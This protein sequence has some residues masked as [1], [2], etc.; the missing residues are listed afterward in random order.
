MTFA[1]TLYARWRVLVHELAKFGIVG[2]INTVVDFGIFN[3]LRV[4]FDVPPL[5]ATAAAL[6]VAATSSY[7]MNRH[8]TFRHRARSG[9]RREYSLFFVLNGVGLLIQLSCLSVS[10]YALGFDS[11]FADN[12]AKAVGLVIG[13]VFRFTSYKRWVFLSH[14]R[15]GTVPLEVAVG[16]GQVSY[17]ADVGRGQHSDNGHARSGSTELPATERT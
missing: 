4:A 6:T 9:L 11:L 17:A 5:P 1:K 2:A 10:H 14:E 13:T 7:L 12:V 8:W 15:A 3:F 16:N